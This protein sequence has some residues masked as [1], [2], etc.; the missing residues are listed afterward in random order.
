[1]S[2]KNFKRRKL[3]IGILLFI[4]LL[5]VIGIWYNYTYSMDKVRAFQ[6]NA[7]THTNKLII[8]TQGSDFK[9]AI[10]ENIVNHYKQDSIFIKVIDIS[11]LPEIN[12]KSFN[13][14]LLIHTWE[15]WKPPINIER[16]I[17]RSANYKSKI[18]VLTTS[19]KGS[20]KMDDVDAITGVSILEN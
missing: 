20:F 4:M 2:I 10:T 9:D 7:P 6:V 11:L 19:G 8:A 15:N 1:M 5:L 17:N 14:I 18:V 13:A 3:I 12:P 16:F